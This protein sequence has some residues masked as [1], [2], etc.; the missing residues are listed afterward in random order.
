MAENRCPMCST[1]NDAA[2]EVCSECGARLKPLVVGTP[3]SPGEES[4][5]PEI[6]GTAGD[7]WLERIRSGI[8]EG[9]ESGSKDAP[10]EAPV[11][12][13]FQQP[14]WLDELPEAVSEEQAGPPSGEIP[15]WMDEFI[16]AGEG[17][18]SEGEEV[19]EWLARIRARQADKETPEAPDLDEGW[20]DRLREDEDADSSVTDTP[21]SDGLEGLAPA[22]SYPEEPKTDPFSTPVDLGPLSDLPG[23]PGS[24][25]RALRRSEIMEAQ[26]EIGGAEADAPVAPAKV[27]ADESEPEGDQPHVPALVSGQSVDRPIVE[28][29]DVSLDSIELPDWLS[30]L[31]PEMPPIDPGE[32]ES[33]GMGPDLAPATLPSWLE[34]MRPVDTFRPEIEIEP[35][36][37]QAVES[38]GPL[39]GLRG[40]L[41]AE[42]VVA[43]P[44]S[45]SVISSQLEITERQ[46]AQA[47]LLHRLVEE[48]EKDIALPAAG[49][50]RLP[51]LRWVISLILLLALVLPGSFERLGFRGFSIPNVVPREMGPLINLVENI[52]AEK[53]ALVVFDFAPGYSGELDTVAS[54]MLKHVLN[55]SVPIITISTHP[56]GP[57]LAER[58]LRNISEETALINGAQYLH[59]GYLSG[60]PT[61]VQLFAIS[62]RDAILTG[63]LLPEGIDRASVWQSPLISAVQRLSDFGAVIV[64]T[65]GTETARN[66]A[67]Q[68]H[69][70]LGDTPLLMVLSAGAE[71]LVRPYFEASDQRVQGI[72][73]GLPS[74]LAY[75]QMNGQALSVESR[76]DGFGS[77]MFAVQSILIAGG[78]YG[79]ATWLVSRR[80]QT[81]GEQDA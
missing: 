78:L 52:S 6:E 57:P 70:W 30:E 34:A 58:L 17:E 71:P 46:Y 63:F 22:P 51:I 40:V 74:A 13:E 9:E 76:W 50:R 29:D 81:R 45:S 36:E 56:S 5:A 65:A 55:R 68:T 7:D 4:A 67:E 59:L 49:G 72:L 1:I 3:G 62:P 44:R 23:V 18:E 12:D 66:W 48:E 10:S 60:G 47:E 24:P 14:E 2:A 28:I 79:A 20:I 32:I 42:P 61:A 25:D 11:Q 64:I 21:P 73:T 19:P 27:D 53:P 80:Q 37:V 41:M 43:K 35:E 16:A 33:E 39:A 31:K 15:G 75:Q 77:M 26:A 8:G 38:A 69:P 54:A